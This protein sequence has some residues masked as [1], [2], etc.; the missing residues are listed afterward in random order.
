M[1]RIFTTLAVLDAGLLLAAFSLGVANKL[2]AGLFMVHFWLGLLAAIFNLLVHCAIFTYFLG[3]GR[4]V[5]EV[6]IAYSL[7]DEPLPKLTREL[8]RS[9]FPP[10][11]FGMLITIAA[12]AAGAAAQVG[13]W[14]WQIHLA[15]GILT[16][17]INAWAFMVE[18]RNVRTNAEVIER[19][20][21][22]VDRIRAERGLPSNRE[23]LEREEAEG[24]SESR[25]H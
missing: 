12:A 7:P 11:L 3:T 19:V 13:V 20:L 21:I 24:R 6:G 18:Y 2:G 15:L 23:A 10:A 17:L 1:K 5:K 22:E 4:W 8:K 25:S 9:T 14:A 16:L